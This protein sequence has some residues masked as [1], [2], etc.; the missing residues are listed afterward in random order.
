MPKIPLPTL[1]EQDVRNIQRPIGEIL[2]IASSLGKW[3]TL[4]NLSNHTDYPNH[5]N[6]STLEDRKITHPFR[7]S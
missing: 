5:P 4:Y 7:I 1:T 6:W 2:S 3:C